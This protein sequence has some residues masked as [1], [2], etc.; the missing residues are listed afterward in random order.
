M[1]T[2]GAFSTF[3]PFLDRG[4]PYAAIGIAQS[5][6]SRFAPGQ[7]PGTPPLPSPKKQASPGRKNSGSLEIMRAVQVPCSRVNPVPIGLC[8]PQCI[9]KTLQTLAKVF[10]DF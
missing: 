8:G 10:V 6:L 5:S 3:T 7:Y 1:L 9:R 4:L 2:F